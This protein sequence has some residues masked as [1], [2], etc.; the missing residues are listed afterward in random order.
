LTGLPSLKTKR[1]RIPRERFPF[2]YFSAADLLCVS[3]VPCVLCVLWGLNF[4][5]HRARL[6]HI[7]LHLLHQR[8]HTFELGF[9]AQTLDELHLHHLIVQIAVEI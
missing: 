9:R 5:E 4:R 8:V 2:P 7:P 1:P 3:C 6:R